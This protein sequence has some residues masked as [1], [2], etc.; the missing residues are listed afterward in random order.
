MQWVLDSRGLARALIGDI[1]GAIVDFTAYV[2]WSK[3][4]DLYDTHGKKREAWI[5]ALQ[6]GENPFDEATLA[7]LRKE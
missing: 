4:N 6:R 1:E 3:E 7:E 2:D 5:A